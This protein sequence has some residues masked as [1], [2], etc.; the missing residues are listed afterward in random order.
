MKKRI[1]IL[2]LIL[3]IFPVSVSAKELC[4]VTKGT[5]KDIGDEVKCGTESF[6]LVSNKNDKIE[7]LAKYNLF[8][9]DK[10]S[11]FDV[12][13]E[14]STYSN[15]YSAS[16]YCSAKSRE[17]GFNAYKTYS[18]G[19]FLN[20]SFTLYGCRVYENIEYDKV[21]QD[22][23]AV[24]T[25]LD[26]TGHS[27]LPLYGIT[28]MNPEWGNVFNGTTNFQNNYDENGNLIVEGS[29][30]KQYLN[31][32]KEELE[33]QEIE[34]EDVSFIT[35]TKTLELLK[36]ISNKDIEVNIEY[37]NEAT[38]TGEFF[39]GKMDIKNYTENNK[40]IY[41]VTYWLGSGFEG[42]PDDGIHDFK[43]DYYISNE[44]MLCAIGRG[45]CTYLPYPIGNGVRP[46][47]TIEKGN[48]LYDIKVETDGNGT[49]EAPEKAYGNDFIRF[50]VVPKE[51]YKLSKLTITTDSGETVEY[52]EESFITNSD[53][54]TSVDS[55]VFTMPF[56]NVTIRASW[57]LDVVETSPTPTPTATLTPT[58][59]ARDNDD[60]DV[61]DTYVG[62]ITIAIVIMIVL[63]SYTYTVVKEKNQ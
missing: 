45:E 61:P 58:E 39:Y 13:E 42:D 44:G 29:V 56:E 62:G 31:G 49:I 38:Y 6:Y 57:R 43:N 53:G 12:D 30:F 8:V 34:V 21:R 22:E 40:W 59:T 17:L 3:F 25:K 28:Y 15:Q 26:G 1:F 63:A 7:L 23:R 24:G 41:D 55:S 47:I 32:Y 5:G 36:N 18:I 20:S 4:Q 35:L 51:G 16:E 54:T 2:I 14:H 10:I 9:G 46:L 27:I 33:R 11:Y 52:T 48:V 37:P 50:K 60:V 19:E